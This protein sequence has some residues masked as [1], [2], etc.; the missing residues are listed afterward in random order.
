MLAHCPAACAPGTRAVL[1]HRQLKAQTTSMHTCGGT[2]GRADLQRKTKAEDHGADN[3]A[4][5][6][7]VGPHHQIQLRPGVHGAVF[8]RQEV[9]HPADDAMCAHASATHTHQQRAA[10]ARS[11]CIG[12]GRCCAGC[13]CHS[14]SSR[15]RRAPDALDVGSL[16][17]W[18][19]P[20]HGRTVS[21]A[22]ALRAALAARGP[23]HARTYAVL[24]DGGSVIGRGQR[25][26]ARRG[27][28]QQL[29]FAPRACC[30]AA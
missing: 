24:G 23:G 4:L 10:A 15:A 20:A 12:H 14:E 28:A 21:G 17:Q 13:R 5:A 30:L 1:R 16:R 9:L 22:A 27:R 18:L 8:V 2:W 25:R 19:G 3:G 26:P 29:T 6:R 11:A 7:T